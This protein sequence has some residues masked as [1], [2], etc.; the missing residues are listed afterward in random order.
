MEVSL[1]IPEK[2]FRF[3]FRLLVENQNA[4]CLLLA[5]SRDVNIVLKAIMSLKILPV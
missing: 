4:Y 3:W 2:K 5:W 1:V